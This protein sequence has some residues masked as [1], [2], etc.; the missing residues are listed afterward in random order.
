MTDLEKEW[1]EGNK[2]T[3]KELEIV[4]RFCIFGACLYLLFLVY[5]IVR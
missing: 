3:I 4:Q 1:Y 5:L 2:K